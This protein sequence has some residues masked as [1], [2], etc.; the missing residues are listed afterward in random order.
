MLMVAGTVCFCVLA[1]GA[2]V[3][4]LSIKGGDEEIISFWLTR[5]TGVVNTLIGLMAGFFA[6]RN[7]WQRTH[8]DEPIQIYPPQNKE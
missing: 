8:A 7:S 4:F 1:S 3:A 6:G 5:V 2:T